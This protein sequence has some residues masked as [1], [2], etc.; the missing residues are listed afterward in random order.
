MRFLGLDPAGRPILE[1]PIYYDVPE[2]RI[3]LET[4][5]GVADQYQRVATNLVLEHLGVHTELRFY[6]YAP[7][8]GSFIQKLGIV[9]IAGLGGWLG[10]G[11]S[12]ITRGFVEGFSGKTPE[13]WAYEVGQSLRESIRANEVK[14]TGETPPET[15]LL[16]EGPPEIEI[17][18]EATLQAAEVTAAIGEAAEAFVSTPTDELIERG[19]APENLPN[20]F[21]QRT[22]LYYQLEYDPQI[23][24]VGFG[25]QPIAPIRR[26]D[27][28]RYQVK[29][30]QRD[31]D[32]WKIEVVKY[33]VSS[34]NWDR[35]DKKRKW[36]GRG[37]DG[38][39]VYFTIDDEKFWEM[40]RNQEIES[41]V[42]DELIAQAAIRYV[43]NKAVERIIVRV[44]SYNDM[45]IS[46][47]MNPTELDGYLRELNAEPKGGLLQS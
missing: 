17:L 30:V 31:E 12:E 19:Y 15:E 1:L 22:E 23:S 13:A 41:T 6:V 44:V 45:P 37:A 34:P 18:D 26:N 7:E 38:R 8:A 21:I 27:F 4:F 39:F 40:A 32:V 11:A 33:R 46:T 14:T 25:P 43:D 36:K 5:F 29:P 10:T 42:I 35:F 9:V 47:E 24:G 2:N 28:S 16:D 20:T 3:R